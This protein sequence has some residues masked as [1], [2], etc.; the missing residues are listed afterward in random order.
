M[1]NTAESHRPRYEVK[2][3]VLIKSHFSPVKEKFQLRNKDS[4]KISVSLVRSCQEIGM[5][6]KAKHK[7]VTDGV[8]QQK[9]D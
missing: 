9:E 3:K 8:R 4:N 5:I 1:V 2:I 6:D 7:G